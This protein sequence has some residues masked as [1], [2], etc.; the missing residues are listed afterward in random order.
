MVVTSV[1]SDVVD[2][3]RQWRELCGP[4]IV[5]DPASP[6]GS[7]W[8]PLEGVTG[9][10]T[11]LHVTRE[12]FAT[13][14]VATP[15]SAFWSTHASKLTAALFAV[16]VES[17]HS[18]FD[19][20][21]WLMSHLSYVP[22]SS[23]DAVSKVLHGY[24]AMEIKT[25][26]GIV[27][28]A[29]ATLDPWTIAQPLVNVRETLRQGGT[30]YLCAPRL[31]QRRF[32]SLFRAVLRTLIEEQEVLAARHDAQPL[33]VVLDEAASIAPLHDLDQMAA[34]L[35]SSKVTFVTVFQDAAQITHRWGTAARTLVNNHV[36]RMVFHGTLDPT[37]TELL[38]ELVPD[39]ATVSSL[40]RGRPGSAKLLAQ[41]LAPM[42]VRARPW[43]SS[44]LRRRVP[45]SD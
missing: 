25:F 8:N 14:P 13:S 31:D 12:L 1:K 7:T 36:Y 40:R 22:T 3:T 29:L 38:P 17:N 20:V 11:A 26:D 4:V 45:Q 32:E 37:T 16:A 21:E 42:T 18:V 34:T 19:V 9:L 2:V 30:V 6:R 43:Y 23:D 15:D 41:N 35:S 33:L 44:P 28:T 27:T 5:L 24:V 39:M 10:R